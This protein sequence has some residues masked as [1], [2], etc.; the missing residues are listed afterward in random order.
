MEL[1]DF[2]EFTINKKNTFHILVTITIHPYVSLGLFNDNI[3]NYDHI[4][5]NAWMIVHT[6]ECRL[7]ELISDKGVS[8]NQKF[9]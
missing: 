1:M 2:Q 4:I 5:L 9:G 8:N 6:A 3:S 7:S